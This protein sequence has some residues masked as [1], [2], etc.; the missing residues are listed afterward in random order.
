[1]RA[2]AAF[3]FTVALAAIGYA[4]S[5]VPGASDYGEFLAARILFATAALSLVGAYGLWLLDNR[6][7]V[8]A[9]GAL[10]IVLGCFTILTVSIG[11]PISFRWINSHEQA[12]LSASGGNTLSDDTI[13]IECMRSAPPRKFP[14][15]GAIYLMGFSAP[16]L[17]L[18][19]AEH[20]M[21]GDPGSNLAWPDNFP[22]FGQRCRVSNIGSVTVLD[23][24]VGLIV[25][26]FEAT[27][28]DGTGYGFGKYI[29]REIWHLPKN[30]LV[31]SPTEAFEFYVWNSGPYMVDVTLPSRGSAH[32]RRRADTQEFALKITSINSF[33]LP[34]DPQTTRPPN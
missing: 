3:L 28:T 8:L 4:V 22:M 15:S 30:S 10:P 9:G 29:D 20:Y 33:S 18:G 23:L 6:R 5:I 11:T 13:T 32:V 7:R 31:L 1:M 19:R 25:R 26:F 24:D 16:S 17:N 12:V 2:L 21:T 14:A 34:P 27:H